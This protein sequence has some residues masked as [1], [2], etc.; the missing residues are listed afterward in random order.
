VTNEVM[1]GRFRKASRAHP[2]GLDRCDVGCR[3]SSKLTPKYENT[4]PVCGAVMLRD[5]KFNWHC[6]PPRLGTGRS[7]PARD[8]RRA[9]AAA[10]QAEQLRALLPE[11]IWVKASSAPAPAPRPACSSMA[12]PIMPCKHFARYLSETRYVSEIGSNHF[13][14]EQSGS[15]CLLPDQPLIFNPPTPTMGEKFYPPL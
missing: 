7:R 2:N 9:I 5:R 1:A 14:R 12:S 6:Q 4:V 8:G 10:E 15:M 3:S 13:E 11:R